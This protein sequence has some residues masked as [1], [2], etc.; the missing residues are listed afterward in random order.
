MSGTY[1]EQDD[2]DMTNEAN[3]GGNDGWSEY[4]EE[5]ESPSYYGVDKD[6]QVNFSNPSSR[7][8]L[9]IITIQGSFCRVHC[10]KNS[11]KT[12]GEGC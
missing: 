10:R 1:E 5:K 4:E 7:V 9:K 12:N 8:S 6:D 2:Y 3:N 11:L